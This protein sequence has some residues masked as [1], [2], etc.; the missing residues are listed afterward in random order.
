MFDMQGG[1]DNWLLQLSP[2]RRK[3]LVVTEDGNGHIIHQQDYIEFQYGKRSS[4]ISRELFGR[5]FADILIDETGTI[6]FDENGPRLK[7]VLS[8]NIKDSAMRLLGRVAEA[9]I[10]RR[11]NEIPDVNY[12]FFN[13]ARRLR[14]WRKTADKYKA[15]GT[16]LLTTQQRY[17]R[18]YNPT[19][20][21]RDIIWIDDTGRVAFAKGGSQ[22]SGIEAGLQIKVSTDGKKYILEDLLKQ[23]Y[24]VPLVY[25]PIN[26][27]FDFLAEKLYIRGA[28]VRDTDGNAR[29]LRIGEDFINVKAIDPEAYEEVKSYEGLCFGLIDGDFTV[30]DLIET[31]YGNSDLKKA[32]MDESLGQYVN[33]SAMI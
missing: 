20:P 21:Q 1:Y 29:L 19:D 14:S 13:K 2:S 28:S 12:K 18:K 7:L 5:R 24:E 11:C 15:I 8:D 23:R 22:I 25:F 16:G 32:I 17:P 33:N 9:V 10:V 4:E 26:N 27:D 30:D 31:A 3:F 6:S